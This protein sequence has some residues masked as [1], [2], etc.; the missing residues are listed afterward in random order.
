MNLRF[1]CDQC[2]P[3]K[4]ADGLRQVGC[5]VQLL[6]DHLPTRAPDADVIAKAQELESVLVSLNG[7]FANIVT[8]PPE[9]FGGIIAIQLHDHPETIPALMA[10]LRR[11]ISEHPD[12]HDYHGK[13]FIVEP[14]RIRIR[15]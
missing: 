4:I 11:F 9:A 6:R 12:P 5:D 14:H 8:Y 13:L 1:F 10:G 7:D 15:S 3:Q 2:V